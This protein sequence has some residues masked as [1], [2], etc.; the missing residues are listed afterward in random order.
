MGQ[1]VS[2]LQAH[3]F[4]AVRLPLSAQIVAARSH[5]IANDFS[6]GPHY[7]GWESISILDDVVHRLRNAG[8]FVMFDMHV[9]TSRTHSTGLWCDGGQQST[10][11]AA[12]ERLIFKAWTKLAERYCSSPNVRETPVAALARAHLPTPVIA[13][14]ASVIHSAPFY[15]AHLL[16]HALSNSVHAHHR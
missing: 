15:V 8:I 11:S 13:R 9:I 12:S 2:F 6:C 7:Q 4:N 10:C 1:Y 3:G 5:K 16:T 14:R